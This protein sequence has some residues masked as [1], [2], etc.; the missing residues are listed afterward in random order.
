MLCPETI[1]LGAPSSTEMAF[2]SGESGWGHPPVT[3]GWGTWNKAQPLPTA[4]AAPGGSPALA[5][6][7]CPNSEPVCWMH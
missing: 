2:L 3:E 4:T 6:A 5:V 7:S 1:E